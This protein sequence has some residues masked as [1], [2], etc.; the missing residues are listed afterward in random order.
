MDGMQNFL[1]LFIIT[2][3]EATIG[4]FVKLTDSEIPI[5]TLNFL[6]WIFV[7]LF[8]YIFILLRPMP[9]NVNRHSLVK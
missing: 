4:I 2:V 5:L 9:S 6:A 1:L 7:T 8:L 3:S